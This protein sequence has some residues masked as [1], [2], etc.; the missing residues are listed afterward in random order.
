MLRN[1]GHKSLSEN[2]VDGGLSK[3]RIVLVGL[4]RLYQRMAPEALRGRCIFSESCSNIV[5]R[6]T[7]ESGVHAGLSELVI[8]WR[9][10][11]P[12]YFRLP[13]S[14]LYPEIGSPVRL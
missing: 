10:C 11:R 4:I 14:Q 9:R 6:R 5:M 8:R 7:R 12:G 13:P 1:R 3:V 2:A